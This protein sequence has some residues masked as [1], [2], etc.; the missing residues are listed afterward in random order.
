[1]TV[2]AEAPAV[3]HPS[4]DMDAKSGSDLWRI[5]TL[6][7]PSPSNPAW[8]LKGAP[9]A[10]ALGHR[11]PSQKPILRMAFPGIGGIFGKPLGRDVFE[12]LTPKG[13]VPPPPPW[14]P[15]TPSSLFQYIPAPESP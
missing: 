12:R 2:E 10:V 14:T 5:L 8:S 7:F 11:G 9:A 4:S 13:G 15:W 3:R 1:M 6:F